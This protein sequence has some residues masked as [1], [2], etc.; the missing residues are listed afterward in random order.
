[1]TPEFRELI[2]RRLRCKDPHHKPNRID[3]EKD[4][5]RDMGS[6]GHRGRKIKE[7]L[8]VRAHAQRRLDD[9]SMGMQILDN[10]LIFTRMLGHKIDIPLA[11]QW[12]V[13]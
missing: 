3:Y 1:M 2:W 7:N 10:K 11:G 13:V 6:S 9:V 8:E 12:R 5:K 4:W